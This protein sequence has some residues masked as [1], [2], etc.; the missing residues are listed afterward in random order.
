MS[1]TTLPPPIFSSG[2]V[3]LVKYCMEACPGDE[4]IELFTF[5]HMLC[6]N[7]EPEKV[8]SAVSAFL[9]FYIGTNFPSELLDQ[10]ERDNML[11]RSFTKN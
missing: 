10:I 11:Y 9:I 5:I 1:E 8:I 7:Q 4:G 2:M 6:K 3:G